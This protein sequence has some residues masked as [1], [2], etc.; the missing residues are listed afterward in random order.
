MEHQHDSSLLMRR[1]I[2]TGYVTAVER[3]SELLQICARSTDET[4]AHEIA[5]A[6]TVRP[7]VADAI[8]AMQVKRFTPDAL[9]KLRGELAEVE[10]GVSHNS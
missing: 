6:F 4:V 9:Q 2:L 10:L 7:E 3:S 1:D 8:L 5:R